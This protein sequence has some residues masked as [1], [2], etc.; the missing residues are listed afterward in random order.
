MTLSPRPLVATVKRW[1]HLEKT[2]RGQLTQPS[3][4]VEPPPAAAAARDESPRRDRLSQRV[5]AIPPSGIRRFFDLIASMDGVIS[6]GVG[7]PDFATPWHIREAVIHS[8][9]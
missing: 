1:G 6:L 8:L 5:R 7:E 9:E 2:T 3:T 4:T